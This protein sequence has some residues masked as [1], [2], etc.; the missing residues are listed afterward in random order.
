MPAWVQDEDIWEKAK[1]S[2]DKTQYPGDSYYKVVASVYKKMGGKIKKEESLF[3]MAER[4]GKIAKDNKLE[5]LK[6]LTNKKE[7]ISYA[8]NK[9]ISERLENLREKD[10]WLYKIDNTGTTYIKSIGTTKYI[11][12]VKNGK[13]IEAKKEI[14]G[15]PYEV[16]PAVLNKF[17]KFL[18][19]QR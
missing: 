4:I 1:K 5:I 18:Q 13:I 14:E 12:K 9:I 19:T 7:H 10:E 6:T 15:T 8:R 2:V 16:E 17:K 11:I 3:I